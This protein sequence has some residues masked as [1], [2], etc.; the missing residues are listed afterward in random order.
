LVAKL[1]HQVEHLPLH[2]HIKASRRLVG[3]D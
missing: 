3:D 2:G 1:D